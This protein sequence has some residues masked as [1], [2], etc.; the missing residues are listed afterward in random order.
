LLPEISA[1]VFL[2]L[3]IQKGSLNAPMEID[4][5]DKCVSDKANELAQRVKALAAI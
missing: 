4:E 2:I 3:Q 1:L 5:L